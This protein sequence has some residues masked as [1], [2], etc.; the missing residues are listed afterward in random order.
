M[1]A[2]SSKE[3]LCPAMQGP[4]SDDS[5]SEAARGQHE[6]ERGPLH[7]PAVGLGGGPVLVRERHVLQPDAAARVAPAAVEVDGDRR[8]RRAPDAHVPHVADPDAGAPAGA[9]AA[10]AVR[11]VVLVD[12]DGVVDAGHGGVGEGDPRHEAALGAAP[13]LDPQ[14]VHGAGEPRRLHRHVLHRLHLHALLLAQAP[15]AEN[16]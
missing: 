2:T 3:L 16:S 4:S 6:T 9:G 7:I 10:A 5:S 11:A 8:R 15:N 12:D 13:C 1:H 14:P